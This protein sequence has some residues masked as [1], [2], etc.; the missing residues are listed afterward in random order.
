M[1]W[2]EKQRSGR[3]AGKYRDSQGV[4]RSAGTF[5]HRAEALREAGKKEVDTRRSL[6]RNPDAHKRT[7]DSWCT[8]W[9]ESRTVEPGTLARDANR[10]DV[11][12]I[13]K[14]TGIPLGQIT[15]QD[16]KSWA[17]DLGR[18]KLSAAT[19]QRIV[20]LFSAS[21]NAAVDAEILVANPAAR[22]KLPPVTPTK[23]RYLTHD[24]YQAILEQ[25]PTDDDELLVQFLTHTGMRF[26]ELAGLH[27]HR[28]DLKRQQV[29]VVDVFDEVQ[30]EIKAYPKGKRA[31]VVPLPDDLVVELAKKKRT[32]GP[33][34]VSHRTGICRSGL[35]FTTTAG[36]VVHRSNWA[37]VFRAAVANANL[38]TDEEPVALEHAT[39]HDLRHTYASWLIQN[40]VSLADVGKLLG[41]VSPSTTQQYAHLAET[42]R[43]AI[44]RA[45]R[46]PEAR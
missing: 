38:G 14:W 34:P 36:T 27:W 28:L 43:S 37:T 2:P 45:L 42:D 11:H 39:I 46:P 19:V 41:H 4:V 20:H 18:T 10:R 15:R 3:W 31:R 24:E 9:W 35:V 8:E 16:V 26:G 1:A 12:L 33:C 32:A 5:K 7:W 30:G 17:A 21:L 40:G 25:L 22:I 44:L 29:T 13:P 6:Q 23:N